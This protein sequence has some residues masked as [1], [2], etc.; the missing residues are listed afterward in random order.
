[1][2]R[3]GEANTQ[4]EDVI[5]TVGIGVVKFCTGRQVIDMAGNYERRR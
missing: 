4:P 2:A 3:L 1:M 5:A